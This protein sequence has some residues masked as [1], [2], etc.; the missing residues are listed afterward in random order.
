M[1]R[2]LFIG[3]VGFVAFVA[4]LA[5][6]V[7]AP[8]EVRHIRKLPAP[9]DV[10][11][12]DTAPLVAALSQA[13]QRLNAAEAS[14]VTARAKAAAAPPPVVDTLSPKL[15]KQR[16]SLAAAVNDLDALLTRVESAPV[17]ASY[18]ALA[19][20]P[21]LA[22]NARIKALIDSLADVDKDRESFGTTG[23]ADPVYLAL[24]ARGTENGQS[25]QQL[26][27]Q[28]RDTLRDQIKRLTI[29]TQHQAITETPA[30][31]TAGW[32]AERDSAQSL[33]N[34]AST[35][36]ISAR[37]RI[38]E[39]N[40]AVA[41]ARDEEQLNAPAMALLAAS[42]VF[43]VAFGFGVTFSD[44]VRH[45]RASADEHE[46]ERL[47]G[48][49]V[50][51]TIAPRPRDPSR[52]R[53]AA[54]RMVSKYFDPGAD[55]YQLTYLH[56]ARAGASRLMLS[57][58]SADTGVAAVVAMNVAAIAADEARSTLLIDT[59]AR[60]SPAAAALRT[61][62]EPG[63]ADIVQNNQN[64]AEV[65]TQAAAG[66]DRFV[67]VVPSGVTPSGLDPKR[68]VEFFRGE[69]A[70]LARHYEAI[71][72]VSSVEQAVAGLPAAFPI[73]D[74]LICARVGYTKIADLNATIDRIRAA[75]G[76]PL[77]IVLW[78]A[79]PP[80]LPKSDRLAR[81]PRPIRTAEMAALTE[82]R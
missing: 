31:D 49:R 79:A 24:N 71:V 64:F 43:G 12:P 63:L 30:A 47:T 51:A 45:P 58:V 25:I 11:R 1:N 44:E 16:D 38:D 39:Y 29:P 17:T 28:R 69:A 62:A 23:A 33:V 4:A 61:H 55:G 41:H 40:Q 67:D 76:N 72:M 27:Q 8:R 15:L 81:S 56:V 14:L 70:R 20:S 50:V 48:S 78:N 59:D 9:I 21:Q 53:R 82:A 10:V 22:N 60:N 54:D 57:I 3:V 2:P 19:E 36:L 74:A 80:A 73:H 46:V 7:V 13:H 6:L 32:V 52:S 37:G 68:V 75:G 18:R 65:T 5:A 42:L 35:A 77:G 66:R 34:E 26:A